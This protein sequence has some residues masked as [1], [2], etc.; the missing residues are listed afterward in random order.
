[1]GDFSYFESRSGD[2]ACS[3]KE[4]FDF[5]GDLRNFK[6]FI[7]P[8]TINDWSAEENSCSF[9]VSMLG[10]VRVVI[11][12]KDQYT[13]IVYAGDAIKKND[14]TLSLLIDMNS[15]MTARARLEL[16]AELNPMMKMIAAKP[17]TQFLELLISEM[18]KFEGW[19]ETIK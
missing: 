17:I 12:E 13:R 14:F 7:P 1:M 3:P 10:T 6:G 18:E 19:R 9:T 11:S 16:N 4:I 8:G 15:D 5:A 2:L